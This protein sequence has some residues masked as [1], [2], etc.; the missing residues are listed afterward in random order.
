VTP[1][2]STVVPRLSYLA[3]SSVF[4]VIRLLPVSGDEKD[5][6]ILVLRHQL[7]ILQP[8]IDTPRLAALLHRLPKGRLRQLQLIVS[9][10]TILRWHRDLIRRRH[11]NISRHQRPGRPA[12]VEY[13]VR[14][15]QGQ[16]GSCGA[17]PDEIWPRAWLDGRRSVCW[18]AKMIHCAVATVLPRPVECVH[19]DQ[20]AAGERDREGRRDPLAL[21][22]HH[23]PATPG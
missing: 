14:A 9:P 3:V 19:P 12:G 11:A 15:A 10:D 8:Q 18:G 23:R 17:A 22:H 4:T 7:A 20:A 5:I 21:S 13:R 16:P 6:E 1:D 2:W